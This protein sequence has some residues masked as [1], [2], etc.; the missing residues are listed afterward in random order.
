MGAAVEWQ[1]EITSFIEEI[2]TR[3]IDVFNPRRD[4]WDSSWEQVASNLKFNEQVTW[5]L[6]HLE[7]SD[8]KAFYFDPNTKSPV[9][10][11]ELGLVLGN[12]YRD[13]KCIVC[14]P[15]GYWRRGNVDI[16]CGRYGATIDSTMGEFKQSIREAIGYYD[17]D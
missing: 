15:E 3:P 12:L 9:T 11:M 2:A 13:N 5:E 4:D 6:E 14:C 7:A 16:T 8:I 17:V 10:L 1:T